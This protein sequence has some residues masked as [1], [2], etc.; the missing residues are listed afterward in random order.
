[1][2]IVGRLAVRP[3]IAQKLTNLQGSSPP[4]TPGGSGDRAQSETST[5]FQKATQPVMLAAASFGSG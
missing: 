1:M 5:P 2:W 4:S 3:E